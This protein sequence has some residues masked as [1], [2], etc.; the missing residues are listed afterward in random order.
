MWISMFVRGR[1][2]KQAGYLFFEDQ[3]N[4]TSCWSMISMKSDDMRG[5]E[6]C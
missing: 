3:F 6:G 1:E 2:A 5:F 4:A